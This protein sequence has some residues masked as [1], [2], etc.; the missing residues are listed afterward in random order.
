[1]DDTVTVRVLK[2]IYYEKV[3]VPAWLTNV[4]I[5]G[6]DADSTIIAWDDHATRQN[7]GTFRTYTMR[8]DGNDISL[9]NLTIANTAGRVGQAVA[10]HTEGD[11]IR[12]YNCRILGN[13]D[14]FY[15]GGEGNRIYA[16]GCYIEG[17]TDY[18]FGAATVWFEQCTLHCLANSYIT[19]ASTPASVTYGY[20]FNHCRITAADEVTKVY[21]GRPWRPYSATLF[22]NCSMGQFIRPSGWHN[23]RNRE[24]ELTT[25][26]GEYG[27]TGCNTDKRVKWAHMLTPQEAAAITPQTV[28]SRHT[29]WNAK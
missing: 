19:A 6:E 18:I 4:E 13:Q 8:I 29:A 27:T 12:L 21:L 11:R 9:R 26:Y 14:T 25:R 2:G 17:T 1:M 15:T 22:L 28:F 3:T 10:L 24:N 20:I 5:V 16:E 7:M 23:W